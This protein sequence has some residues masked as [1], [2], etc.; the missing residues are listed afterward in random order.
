MRKPFF[1]MTALYDY[2]LE[3]V[4]H[5]ESLIRAGIP[6]VIDGSDMGTGKT[7]VTVEL[8]RRLD[9]P[10]VVVCPKVSVPAWEDW[11]R[12]G[13][14]DFAAIGYD[15]LRTG[16]TAFGKW[17]MRRC[18]STTLHK[19][20]EERVRFI[21]DQSV[22]CVVFDE[23]H[24]CSAEDSQNALMMRG[25]KEQGLTTVIVTA[26]PAENPLQLKAIGYTLG[27]HNW[28]DFEAFA[29]KY[30]CYTGKF[31]PLQWTK[32]EARQKM[33]L[34][35]LHA[36]MWPRRGVRVRK[37]DPRVAS[38]FA[39]GL[40]STELVT[41]DEDAAEKL[42]GVAK[43]QWESVQHARSTGASEQHPMVLFLRTMQELELLMVPALV[44]LVN[45]AVQKG[46]VCPVF[47]NYSGTIDALLDKFPGAP[48]IDGRNSRPA[49]RQSCM[50]AFQRD[51]A[52][53]MLLQA[54]AGSESI[55]LHDLN[56]RHPRVGFSLP[57]LSARLFKQETGRIDRAGTLTE[58]MFRVLVAAGTQQEKVKKKL[59]LKVSNL[60]TLVDGDLN[61]FA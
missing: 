38:R 46:A 17:E 59:D 55:S 35:K 56:G 36:E 5:I 29:R 1:T 30:G 3:S 21:W 22:S 18:W 2:Q 12:R 45:E 44:E 53:V 10:T 47:V 14:T 19:F 51:E 25:A 58:W 15:K 32:D 57:P 7:I 8:L 54:Q 61:M 60:D 33:F 41:V 11:G 49:Y 37:T 6:G 42:E 26:T 9:V 24:R 48:V 34:E 27:L 16:T 23:G 43:I 28:K 50:E 31:A 39:K 40:I 20:Q 52:P 13:T 4:D